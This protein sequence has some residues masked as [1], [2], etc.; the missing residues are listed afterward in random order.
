[1]AD[2]D[3]GLVRIQR[4]AMTDSDSQVVAPDTN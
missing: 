2:E 4:L 1:M 3:M